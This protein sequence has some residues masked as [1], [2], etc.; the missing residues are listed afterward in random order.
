M[1]SGARDNRTPSYRGR[2]IFALFR[3]KNSIKRLHEVGKTTRGGEL[4]CSTGRVT[5]AGETT[6]SHV[7]LV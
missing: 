1:V 2:E 6:F 3:L 7:S 5:W 4:S